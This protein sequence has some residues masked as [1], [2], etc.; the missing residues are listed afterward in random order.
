MELPPKY[1]TMQDDMRYESGVVT[2]VKYKGNVVM[3]HDNG[4]YCIMGWMTTTYCAAGTTKEAWRRAKQ[5]IDA[6]AEQRVPRC[7]RD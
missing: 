5:T 4:T 3:L 1:R 2:V 7:E 6:E